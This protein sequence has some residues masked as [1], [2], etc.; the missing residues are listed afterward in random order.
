MPPK[1]AL[2]RR[3]PRAPSAL[4]P[5]FEND[6]FGKSLV[7]FLPVRELVHFSTCSSLTPKLKLTKIKKSLTLIDTSNEWPYAY[8]RIMGQSGGFGTGA[9]EDNPGMEA[10]LARQRE[11]RAIEERKGPK[12]GWIDWTAGEGPGGR[13]GFALAT[14]P[15]PP[16]CH[17]LLFRAQFR[18]ECEDMDGYVSNK[19]PHTNR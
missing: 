2:R 18:C 10:L 4:A 15:K 3:S 19:L 6:W 7:L 5:L 17:S 14:L 9:W 13:Q 12:A 1:K 8:P 16:P 11:N